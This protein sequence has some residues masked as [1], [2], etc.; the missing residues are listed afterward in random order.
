M[1]SLFIVHQWTGMRGVLLF[2]LG[3]LRQLG[4]RYKKERMPRLASLD[5]RVESDGLVIVFLF[6]SKTKSACMGW[7]RYANFYWHLS[8]F[9]WNPFGFCWHSTVSL[10]A[11][12]SCWD[13][14][15]H[16]A[17]TDSPLQPFAVKL[18]WLTLKLL[19][20]LWEMGLEPFPPFGISILSKA[21]G[22]AST[23]PSEPPHGSPLLMGLNILSKKAVT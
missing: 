6:V 23:A 5:P 19:V 8:D 11:D 15:T 9:C 4:W 16:Y 3:Q 14:R 7:G 10:S 20:G 17:R 12:I 13:L 1:H 21:E 22:R 2:G 18:S